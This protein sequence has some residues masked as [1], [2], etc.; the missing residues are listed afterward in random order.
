M[1][2]VN[3]G[4]RYT[5]DKKD[6][7]R[8]HCDDVEGAKCVPKRKKLAFEAVEAC[9]CTRS[10]VGKFTFGRYGSNSCHGA[11]LMP[12]FSSKILYL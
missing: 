7:R 10:M 2:R 12:E 5:C 6:K 3:S 11:A 1:H 4:T 9:Q 8:S